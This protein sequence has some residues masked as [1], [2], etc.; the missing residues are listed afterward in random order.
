M[1]QCFFDAFDTLVM[2]LLS[3]DALSM[4]AYYL[5][6][7]LMVDA[8]NFDLLLTRSSVNTVKLH[9]ICSNKRI[10][11]IRKSIYILQICTQRYNLPQEIFQ[12]GC[13]KWVSFCLD[14]PVYMQISWGKP[15]IG[16]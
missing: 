8:A 13:Q 15:D 7:A 11:L 5:F 4:H 9:Q 16:G 6:D 2:N 14:N 1:R 3:F 10:R 12:N